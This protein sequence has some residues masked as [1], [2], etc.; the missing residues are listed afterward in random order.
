[1]ITLKILGA[2]LKPIGNSYW[3][4]KKLIWSHHS[5]P[6]DDCEGGPEHFCKLV[7]YLFWPAVPHI[8]PLVP[9]VQHHHELLDKPV[10]TIED[11]YHCWCWSVRDEKGCGWVS[12]WAD[13]DITPNRLIW[14]LG[15]E[16]G[17]IDPTTASGLYFTH[18]ILLHYFWVG[19]GQGHVWSWWTMVVSHVLV[20][21][22]KSMLNARCI[23]NVVGIVPICMVL[24]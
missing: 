3:V 6:V 4:Y 17:F 15:M 5:Y 9:A 2:E 23:A 12:S 11:Q 16:F 18:D 24:E 8:L 1:M 7:Q 14:K 19:Q 10:S 22:S 21:N 20:S 13:V